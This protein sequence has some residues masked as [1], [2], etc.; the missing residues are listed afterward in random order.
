MKLTDWNDWVYNWEIEPSVDLRAPRYTVEMYPALKDVEYIQ[1]VQ[2]TPLV[3][4]EDAHTVSV[5]LGQ[6]SKSYR[7]RITKITTED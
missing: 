3:S 7:Y 6:C 2:I 1:W 5:T 4:F